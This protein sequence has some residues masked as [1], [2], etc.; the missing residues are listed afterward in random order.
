MGLT[1]L[2]SFP[3]ATLAVIINMQIDT[4]VILVSKTLQKPNLQSELSK[5]YVVGKRTMN[6]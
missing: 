2:V 3:G 4:A 5:L 6:G 1:S